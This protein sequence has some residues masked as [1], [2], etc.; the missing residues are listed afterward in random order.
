MTRDATPSPAEIDANSSLSKMNI[1]QDSMATLSNIFR[2]ATRFR[3][4]VEREVL[5]QCNLSFSTFTILWITWI[6]GPQEFKELALDCGVSKGT[7]TGLI[8]SLTKNDLVARSAH[9]TDGRRQI[10]KITPRGRSLI[11]R[12]FPKVNQL[13]THFT[14]NLKVTEKREVA[15]L[16]RIILNTAPP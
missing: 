6:R 15:K 8:N 10:I 16:L 14:S 5:A 1:D 7:M 12:I 4:Y 11:K 2:V 13:E 9:E 3:S